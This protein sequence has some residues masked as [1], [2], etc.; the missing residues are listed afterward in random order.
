MNEIYTYCVQLPPGIHEVVCPCFD[1]YT[2][3]LNSADCRERQELSYTHAMRH[4]ANGDFE[5]DTVQGIEKNA[6]K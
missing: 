6:H 4:I 5:K 2:I 1:G 3:Y